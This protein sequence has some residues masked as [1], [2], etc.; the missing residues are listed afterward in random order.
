MGESMILTL[1]KRCAVFVVVKTLVDFVLSATAVIDIGDSTCTSCCVLSNVIGEGLCLRS[2]RGKWGA[3]ATI[4]LGTAS[5]FSSGA[6]LRRPKLKDR[7]CLGW[8]ESS[9]KWPSQTYFF[10]AFTS[11]FPGPLEFFMKLLHLR[12]VS[13]ET[14]DLS[15]A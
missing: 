1:I 10:F 14:P 3:V 9:L 6:T 4:M 11:K 5:S 15:T 8:N 7:N 2:G 12:S 13:V